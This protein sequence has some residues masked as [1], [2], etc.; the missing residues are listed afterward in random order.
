[1]LI[2][3]INTCIVDKNDGKKEK[4][5]ENIEFVVQFKVFFNLFYVNLQQIG[6][7]KRIT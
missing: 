2:L 6:M 4:I 5:K 7:M 1:M 3:S